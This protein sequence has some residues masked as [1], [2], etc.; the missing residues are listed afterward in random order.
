M[1]KCDFL[2]F[3]LCPLPFVLLLGTTEKSLALSLLPTLNQVFIHT[4]KT[5]P[6]SFL[7]EAKQS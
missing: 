2:Y 4:D 3:S 5:A 1:I 6:K 7:L